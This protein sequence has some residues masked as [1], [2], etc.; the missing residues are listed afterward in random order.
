MKQV[1][2]IIVCYTD[3]TYE[4]VQGKIQEKDVPKLIE[5]YQKMYSPSSNNSL[6]F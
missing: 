2:R 1:N 4:E 5:T 6:L 3:G